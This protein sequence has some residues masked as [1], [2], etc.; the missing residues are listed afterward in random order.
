MKILQ[1][2]VYVQEKI[3]IFCDEEIRGKIVLKLPFFQWKSKAVFLVAVKFLGFKTF[4]LFFFGFSL[5]KLKSKLLRKKTLEWLNLHIF[6]LKKEKHTVDF[7]AVI[8]MVQIF[9]NGL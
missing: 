8:R 5:L 1:S 7:H 9:F 3:I 2:N 6:S 4:F